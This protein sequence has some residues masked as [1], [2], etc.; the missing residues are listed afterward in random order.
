MYCM[1]N[2]REREID[3]YFNDHGTA[4]LCVHAVVVDWENI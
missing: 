4:P 2:E 3:F 1:V